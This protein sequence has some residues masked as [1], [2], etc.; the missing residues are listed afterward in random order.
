M[1]G[2]IIP[3]IATTNAVVAGLVVMQALVFLKGDY[4]DAKIPF[5]QTV[6][7]K[8]LG[9]ESLGLPKP[10]CPVCRDTYVPL[11]ADL[12]VTLGD[13]LERAKAWLAPALGDDEMEVSVLEGARVLADPDFDDNHDRTLEDLGVARGKMITLMDEDDK[14]RPIHFCITAPGAEP[15]VFPEQPPTLALRPSAPP[16]EPSPPSSPLPEAI[17]PPP[18]A[19]KRAAEEPAERATKKRKVE[20]AVVIDDDEDFAIIDA[21]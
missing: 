19:K 3:A 14:Y 8:P 15:L 17:S 9:S 1:A 20:E 5:I 13:F 21:A 7:S 18:S 6:P 10:T 11:K 16:K 2:N 4:A 12:Q